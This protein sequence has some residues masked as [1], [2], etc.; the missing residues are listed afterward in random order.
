M[1]DLVELETLLSSAEL[2]KLPRSCT[3]EVPGSSPLDRR[4]MHRPA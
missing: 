2:D 3:K 1:P 4:H